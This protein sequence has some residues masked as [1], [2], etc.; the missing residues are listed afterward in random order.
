M[1]AALCATGYWMYL[2]VSFTPDA[3][4]I[5]VIIFNAAF[6]YSWGPL[7]WLYPP[8]VCV[9]FA[10]RWHMSIMLPRS[11]RCLCA[12]KEYHSP[13]RKWLM[14]CSLTI[15]MFSSRTNWAFNFLVG[16]AT[17]Y[18]QEVITWRLYVMHG[19]FCACSVALGKATHFHIRCCWCIP[20]QFIFVSFYEE[21]Q[22]WYWCLDLVYP[23]TK[24]VPLEE[25]D[26]VFGEGS[27][28][29]MPK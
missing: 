23:E 17:P 12:P 25:M 11:C 19:F 5:C 8:E 9:V 24:G 27:I 14:A 10:W 18:L 3:V 28:Y 21:H 7:P 26:A 6:G 22:S 16:E 29:F 4:V 2:N 20:E 15:L 1:C 13:P